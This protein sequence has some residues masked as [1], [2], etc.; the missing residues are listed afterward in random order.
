MLQ[1]RFSGFILLRLDDYQ[2]L[3]CTQEIILYP[4]ERPMSPGESFL[5]CLKKDGEVM[6]ILPVAPK[7]LI[8]HPEPA[9]IPYEQRDRSPTF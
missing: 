5:A 1:F 3:Q 8:A 7:A 9:T 2:L 6:I 4:G